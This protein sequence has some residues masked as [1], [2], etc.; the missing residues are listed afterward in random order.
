MMTYKDRSFCFSK[1]EKHTCGRELTK[2]DSE[3]AA[4]LG[5]YISGTYYCAPP[6]VSVSIEE[7]NL[8]SPTAQEDILQQIVDESQ[9]M[10]LY[11]DDVVQTYDPMP[12][13]DEQ[14]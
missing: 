6:T 4:K 9:A 1:V 10:G 14:G 3:K 5:L 13:V 11:D 12:I 8:A 7:D 2:E